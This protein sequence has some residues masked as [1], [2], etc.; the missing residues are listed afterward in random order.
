MHIAHVIAYLY[1]KCVLYSKFELNEANDDAN[2]DRHNSHKMDIIAMLC[3]QTVNPRHSPFLYVESI[4]MKNDAFHDETNRPVVVHNTTNVACVC[5]CVCW[6]A[7]CMFMF[8]HVVLYSPRN[9]TRC[10]QPHSIGPALSFGC[11]LNKNQP[12]HTN[13]ISE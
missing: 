1:P 12:R 5:V 13:R 4:Y 6:L 10:V 7:V 2:E 11:L 8:A 9:A 3:I